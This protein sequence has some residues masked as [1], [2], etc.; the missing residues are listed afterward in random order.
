MQGSFINKIQSKSGNYNEKIRGREIVSE[1][2]E[3]SKNLKNYCK[4]ISLTE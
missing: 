1:V 3:Q 4:H 2:K